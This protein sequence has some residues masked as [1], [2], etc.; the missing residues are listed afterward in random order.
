RGPGGGGAGVGQPSATHRPASR[1][2]L[3]AARSVL[4]IR[5][6]SWGGERSAADLSEIR[7]P[8]H[9]RPHLAEQF[10][11]VVAFGGD[12]RVHHHG[13]EEGVDRS[14]EGGERLHG[15]GEVLGFQGGVD[16]GRGGGGRGD[17]GGLLGRGG[18]QGDGLAGRQRPLLL[19]GAED[20]GGALVAGQQIGPV[21]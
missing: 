11:A 3:I 8:A 13:R 19:L 14:A 10:Q 15:G 9:D 1:P 6:R 18:G 12:V 21:I 2:R 20:V 7:H 17:E 4:P 5:L 16:G